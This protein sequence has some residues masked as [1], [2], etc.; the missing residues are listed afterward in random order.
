M[1]SITRFAAEDATTLPQMERLSAGATNV[2]A[3]GLLDDPERFDA[4]FFGVSPQEA[5]LIDPQHRQ[6]V[7]VTYE[8]FESAA[9]LPGLVP[10]GVFAGAGFP[11][12][13]LTHL[14]D[15]PDLEGMGH[16]WVTVGN[17][18]DH[19]A[20]R[21]SYLL[22]LRGPTVAVQ[23]ACSTSL[24]CVHLACQSLLTGECDIAVAGSSAITFPQRRPY[25]VVDGGI[26]SPDGVCR[27][28]DVGAA[29]TVPANGVAAVVLKRLSDAQAD[30]DPIRAIIQGTAIGN[31]AVDR[32][33]YSAPSVSGQATVIA[34]SL[35]VA[36]LRP[37]EVSYVEAHGTG[38]PLGDP[39]EIAAL[40]R[41][42]PATHNQSPPCLL[43][44]VKGNIGHVDVAAGLAGLIKTVLALEHQ[45][46]PASLHFESP[47]PRLDL[48]HT[49]F[50]V[51][52][53]GTP[54][55]RA[56]APRIA[57]VSSFGLGGTNAHIVVQE[58]P[59][60]VPARPDTTEHAVPLLLSADSQTALDTCSEQLAAT[61]DDDLAPSARALVHGRRHRSHRRVVVADAPTRAREQ[62]R[63]DRRYAIAEVEPRIA[64]VFSGAGAIPVQ[65]V[66]QLFDWEAFASAYYS[67]AQSFQATGVEVLDPG[68]LAALPEQVRIRPTVTLPALFAV[69]VALARLWESF[70]V[71][72]TAVCGHSA[73]EYA[74]A[75]IAGALPLSS[76]AAMISKRARLLE[77]TAPGHIALVRLGHADAV[78]LAERAGVHVA[79]VN[80]A[81]T[82]LI[83]GDEEH[84]HAMIEHVERAGI[85]ARVVAVATAAHTPS[86]RSAGAE[87]R[88]LAATVEW[89]QPEIT[90]VS[91]M[92][93]ALAPS[94][95]I[96]SPAYWDEHLWRTVRF[97]KACDALHC[98]PTPMRLSRLG[99]REP[100]NLLCAPIFRT[101]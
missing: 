87:L 56:A 44:S 94:T 53:T 91:G 39:I 83:A 64:F 50:R 67:A 80:S 95:E 29:G 27:P 28:F 32:M 17:D 47:N 25:P 35:A 33:S 4:D 59:A 37:N 63:S 41:A 78:T 55:P 36:G 76:A 65:H 72:P 5:K 57:G 38:T 61:V 96:T 6:L 69:Q 46:I 93:G 88:A 11:T 3:G 77:T 43:G 9:L 8:A 31:D 18:K 26:L 81:D 45:A 98:G 52:K 30:G 7:E 86:L 79:A 71:R 48:S 89:T 73:G 40:N 49:R 14:W 66:A 13:P 1:D 2:Y 60:N 99:R 62:L 20:T 34:D 22:G 85:D 12:Y 97:D 70:G 84:F 10:T 74:A 16:Y 21:V 58:A 23:S 90:Y 101:Q 42:M 82:C 15:S 24:V 68:S 92:T 19:I 51:A 100:S 54:W 75:H